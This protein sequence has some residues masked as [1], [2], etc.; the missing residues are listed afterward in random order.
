MPL[1]RVLSTSTPRVGAEHYVNAATPQE[2]KSVVELRPGDTYQHLVVDWTSSRGQA[3]QVEAV[4]DPHCHERPAEDFCEVCGEP[5][6]LS[7]AA[8]RPHAHDSYPPGPT[9]KPAKARCPAC[10]K[11]WISSVDTDPAEASCPSCHHQG[12]IIEVKR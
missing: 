9:A 7:C 2:A 8:A 11:H 5:I 12:L 6:C 3:T 1:Y 10:R 4:S